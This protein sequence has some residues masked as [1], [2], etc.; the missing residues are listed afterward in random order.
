MLFAGLTSAY[1]IRKSGEDWVSIE[2][3]KAFL[4]STILIILSS[5][6]FHICIYYSKLKKFYL[7]NIFMIGTLTL[8][9]LFLISQINGFNQLVSQGFYFTGNKSLI[10]SSFF[11]VITAC[12]LVHVLLTIIVVFI[13]FFINFRKKIANPLNSKLCCMFWDFL[14]ILWIYLYI[15]LSIQ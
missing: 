13:V 15:F 11:Y 1:L 14:G 5:I 3:P 9:I 2:I 12:H 4:L 6:S 7:S 10:S 8:G